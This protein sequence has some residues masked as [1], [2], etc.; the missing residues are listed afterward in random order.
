MQ[1]R[2]ENNINIKQ[3]RI[4]RLIKLSSERATETATLLRFQTFIN[5]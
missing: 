5:F 2:I 4:M 1:S 3:H